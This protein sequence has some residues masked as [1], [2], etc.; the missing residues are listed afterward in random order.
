MLRE[1]YNRCVDQKAK[2]DMRYINGILERWHKEGITSPAQI[3]EGG[4]KTDESMARYDKDLV[5]TLLNKDD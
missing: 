3:S 1:A 2:L 4:K 5:K